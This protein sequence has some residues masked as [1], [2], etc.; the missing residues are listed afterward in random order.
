[1]AA[2]YSYTPVDLDALQNDR[3]QSQTTIRPSP[4]TLKRVSTYYPK[5][6][7]SALEDPNLDPFYLEQ[8]LPDSPAW[9]S[10]APDVSDAS[11]PNQFF[12]LPTVTTGKSSSPYGRSARSHRNH[13][14]T[15]SALEIER[16][17]G[18]QQ[19]P[20]HFLEEARFSSEESFTPAQSETPELSPSSSFSSYYSASIRPNAAI[21]A[22]EQL[23][24]H[25]N[26]SEVGG[27]FDLRPSARRYKTSAPQ[28]SPALVNKPNPQQA[29]ESTQ[30][31]TM[32]DRS[33]APQ[34]W[35]PLPALPNLANTCGSN[36][37]KRGSSNGLR[38]QIE[39]SMISPPSLL[40]PVTLEPHPSHFDQAFFIPANDCPSPVP[41]PTAR[42]PLGERDIN[43]VQNRPSTSTFDP[44]CERSVW[45]SDSDDES[46][47]RKSLS[48]KPI[49][50]IRKVRSRAK[51]R[52]AKST[53]KLNATKQEDEDQEQYPPLPTPF[54]EL[55]H[56]GSMTSLRTPGKDTFHSP[57]QETLRL[58]APSATSL[59]HSPSQKRNARGEYDIDRSTA[60]AMQAKSRRRQHIAP[61]THCLDRERS[62]SISRDECSDA[63]IDESKS[64]RDPF[65]R[66]V[67]RSLRFLSCRT[68]LPENRAVRPV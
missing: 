13:Q 29:N 8:S 37:T 53:P 68:G 24:Q 9:D 25:I 32:H 59:S 54:Q 14:S 61:D 21:R 22:T 63:W 17:L 6:D 15:L 19:Y 3:N 56:K 55:F 28:P 5:Q 38:T 49:D 34:R 31:A 16:S 40:D 47:G 20:T 62:D 66:R 46:I 30:T 48:R 41:S 7:L 58:V 52:V 33:H 23:R 42:S 18:F 67:W 12:M 64:L 1:M 50:T 11:D 10:A 35:K 27:Q 39:P 60:A 36:L 65:F 26:G 45:E 2:G 43:T 51:L 4:P 44:Y 57:D